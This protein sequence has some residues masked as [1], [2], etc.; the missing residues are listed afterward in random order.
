MPWSIAP[1]SAARAAE[2]TSSVARCAR[3]SLCARSGWQPPSMSIGAGGTQRLSADSHPGH[4]MRLALRRTTHGEPDAGARLLIAADEMRLGLRRRTRRPMR[5]HFTICPKR[6][7]GSEH[8]DRRGR[9]LNVR[10]GRPPG[11]R[12]PCGWRCGSRL[13]RRKGEECAAGTRSGDLVGWP[14]EDD[15]STSV[16]RRPRAISRDTWNYKY[17]ETNDETPTN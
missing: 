10:R 7:A 11:P 16:V 8:L 6:P 5:A 4:A 15:A 13:T 1:K 14:G 3:T 9:S 12:T 2:P 17:T